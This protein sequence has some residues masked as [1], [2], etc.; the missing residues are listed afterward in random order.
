MSLLRPLVYSFMVA[1]SASGCSRATQTS[2][3]TELTSAT[4]APFPAGVTDALITSGD[5]LFNSGAC[6]R[7]HGARGVGGANGPSLVR[8]PWLH[9]SDNVA[10]IARVITNGVPQEQLKSASRRFAMNPRGGPMALTDAQIQSLAAYVWS[11]S[12]RKS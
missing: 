11:I 4:T 10:D 7:C 1:G 8:G 5:R 3:T 12:R 2:P 9:A 6:V